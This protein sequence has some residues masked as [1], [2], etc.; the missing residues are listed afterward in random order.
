MLMLLNNEKLEI[1]TPLAWIPT[2]LLIISVVLIA[3]GI[4]IL[5]LGLI[6]ELISFIMV[7]STTNI[8]AKFST[9]GNNIVQFGSV[10]FKYKL[11]LQEKKEYANSLLKLNGNSFQTDTNYNKILIES[12]SYVEIKEKVINWLLKKQEKSSIFD[13]LTN[14]KFWLI[15]GAMA[16]VGISYLAIHYYYLSETT[17]AQGETLNSIDKTLTEQGNLNNNTI[18]VSQS[19]ANTIK[20]L[21]AGLQ[22]QIDV[23]MEQLTTYKGKQDLLI[24]SAEQNSEALT[25]VENNLLSVYNLMALLRKA[26]ASKLAIELPEIPEDVPEVPGKMIFLGLITCKNYMTYRGM[27]KSVT[28]TIDSPTLVLK[29]RAKEG[30]TLVEKLK[31]M[32]EKQTNRNELLSQIKEKLVNKEIED[33]KPLVEK[34][35]ST[36]EEII[37]ENVKPISD[38]LHQQEI[39]NQKVNILIEQTHN[40]NKVANEKLSILKSLHKIYSQL[41]E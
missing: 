17:I 3:S 16:V 19:L 37:P 26:L 10:I 7:L 8:L 22:K 24:Q 11:S 9:S 40:V 6:G 38:S 41:Y 27:H 20:E 29:L 13:Y 4:G 36:L 25:E 15:V 23:I 33:L 1:I 28:Q 30:Q 39:Q 18:Q 32:T 14:M 35:L 2:S 5:P 31:A 34:T 12:E 21:G